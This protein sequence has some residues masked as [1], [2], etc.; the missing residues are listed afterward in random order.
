MK[1]SCFVGIDISKLTLDV[2][3]F[4]PETKSSKHFVVNNNSEGFEQ[5]KKTL[6]QLG[7][8]SSETF[9]CME[10]CGIYCVKLSVYLTQQKIAFCLCNALHLKRTL[11]LVRGKN[12]K[13]DAHN[14][15]RFCYMYRDE[16]SPTNIASNILLKIA[17]LMSERSRLK[18]AKQIEIQIISEHSDYISQPSLQRAINRRNCLINDLKAIEKEILNLIESDIR[19]A[20]NYKLLTSI[21]SI[22]FVNALNFILKTNNF[23]NIDQAR[24]YACYCGVAPF[25]YSSGTSIRGKTRV[26]RYANRQIKADL[27]CAARSAIIHDPELKIY[28]QRKRNEGKAYG[29][30]LNAVKFK[31]ITRAFA[32]VKRGEPY[33]KLRQAG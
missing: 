5:I 15:S 12:D 17:Q 24:S 33:V 26:S 14:I 27:T 23:E 21:P 29:T 13:L 16:L 32:V 4:Y 18:K 7:F 6:K 11:G 25:E 2:C 20:K 30:V 1:R 8:K 9:I 10:H 28:F 3:I 31:L 22:A 19:L